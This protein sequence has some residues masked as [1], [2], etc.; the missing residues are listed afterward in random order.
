MEIE[1]SARLH[2]S[3]IDLNGYEGRLD[4]GIGIT[5]T[6]PSLKISCIESDENCIEFDNSIK[7]QK[8]EVY[9]SKIMD[10]TKKM[11]EYLKIDTN[12]SFQI[13]EL[14]PIHQGLGLGTQLALSIAKLIS[15]LN[16]KDLTV[17]ELATII[18][19][20]G[21][22]GIGV[23]SFEKGGL[24]ID[25]GHKKS[26]KKDYLPSSAS[27]V[28][29]PPLIAR[30]DFPEDWNILLIRPDIP[31]GASGNKEVKKSKMENEE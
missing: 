21:T 5:L 10:A 27:K 1:T 3:L 16:N 22:S 31:P 29:P 9:T 19:R 15:S 24:L 20:G 2:L 12:Y 23:Y 18:Q 7:I 11:N 28:S 25:G 30:Y 17:N 8:K 26:I 13:K 4:G 6:D 14:Y